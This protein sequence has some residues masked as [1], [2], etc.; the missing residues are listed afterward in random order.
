MQTKKLKLT[1]LLAVAA[2]LPQMAW[3]EGTD[4]QYNAAVAAL[5][6]GGYY[7]IST[8]Y[9]ATT[10]YLKTDGTLTTT[11]KD[12]G[13]FLFEKQAS[14]K[15]GF[16][17]R[18]TASG[19]NIT[20]FTNADASN[21][22]NIKL[23][24]YGTPRAD[25]D[26]QVFYKEGDLYAI[27]ST[28]KGSGSYRE[29]AYWNPYEDSGVKA[30]YDLT[31]LGTPHF[32]W[33]VT[34]VDADA[35]FDVTKTYELKQKSTSKYIKRYA[36]TKET[37]N[38]PYVTT[39]AADI[40]QFF[41]LPVSGKINTFYVYDAESDVYLTPN[42]SNYNSSQ[43]WSFSTTPAEV[44]I[45]NMSSF[46][47]AAPYSF[48]NAGYSISNTNSGMMGF[49]N[50]NGSDQ[51]I[52]YKADDNGSQWDVPKKYD[53]KA[54]SLNNTRSSLEILVNAGANFSYTVT[55]T[56]AGFATL[57]LPF[58]ADLP[59]GTIEA[60]E[61]TSVDGS[62]R[63]Q[64]TKVT[65]ITANKPVLLKGTGSVTLTGTANTAYTASPSNG[66]L[67]GTYVSGTVEAGNYVLQKLNDVVAFYKVVESDK[68]TINPFRAYLSAPAN[69]RMLNFSFGD[70]TTGIANT[71]VNNNENRVFNLQGQRVVQPTKGIYII[72]GKKTIIK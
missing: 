70:E 1:L 69:A 64:G 25:Y 36:L 61:L 44:K 48:A 59:D 28:N 15:T 9:S 46:Y 22:G 20:Y 17:L 14:W 21:S 33:T 29:N 26:T 11:Q 51:V 72:N 55:M 65:T 2:L 53:N 40:V 34:R 32:V 43:T 41:V 54:I 6:D 50:R 71:N 35:A 63:I 8:T 49:A 7:T 5:V 57:V 60:W 31:N 30:G 62:N 67:H 58:T 19:S 4:D 56:A 37:N 12:Q 66:L 45:A 10:Y 16:T 3:A 68:P 42:T 13:I 52:N 27:R 24:S 39:T 18:G 47:G 23:R 38:T